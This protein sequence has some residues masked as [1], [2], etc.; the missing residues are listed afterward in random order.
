MRTFIFNEEDTLN[1]SAAAYPWWLC[2]LPPTAD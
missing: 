2:I 1:P